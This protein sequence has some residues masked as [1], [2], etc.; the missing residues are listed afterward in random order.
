MSNGQEPTRNSVVFTKNDKAR[1]ETLAESFQ[2]VEPD[3]LA[4]YLSVE[5]DTLCK[6]PPFKNCNASQREEIALRCVS[7]SAVATALAWH[8]RK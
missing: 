2:A 3:R 6:L 1:H 5:L 4:D 7:M 8:A